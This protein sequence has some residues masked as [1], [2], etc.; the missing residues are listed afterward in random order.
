MASYASVADFREYM[1]QI[2][3]GGSIDA[4]IQKVLNRAT[5]IINTVLG[6]SF[7][8][9][10][11]ASE[12]VV[13]GDGT[14]FLEPPVFVAESVSL[15]EAP[16]GYTVPDYI[17]LEGLL[18]VT[19]GEALLRGSYYLQGGLYGS[20]LALPYAGGWVAGVPY[21]VT[22]EYG[23]SAIPDD[24]VECCLE[25]AVRIWRAKDAG[26]SDVVGVEG[27]GAVGYNGAL[28][29]LVREVLKHRIQSTSPG[30]H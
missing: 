15:V 7:T 20:T 22:A 5:G 3:S 17:E 10:G 11:E 18:V 23:Y 30:V 21:T 12:Q 26:F 19:R 25:V 29:S 9:A 2:A 13:Y 27:G 4:K 16:D 1:E 28:P 8:V 24:I 6:Y 14:D